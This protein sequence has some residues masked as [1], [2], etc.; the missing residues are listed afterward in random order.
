M[1]TNVK[2]FGLALAVAVAFVFIACNN[3]FFPAK[4]G[5]KPIVIIINVD[6]D[7]EDD[8]I[9]TK[10]HS[11][12]I[13]MIDNESGDSISA[14]PS[15][16]DVG[17]IVTLN[18]TVANTV[19]YNQLNFGGVSASIAQVPSAGSGTRTYTI[20]P[21]D[22]S[23]GGRIVIIATFNHTDLTLDPI[24]FATPSS[25]SKTYGDG[26]FTNA[27]TAR[28]GSG[29]ISYSSGDETVATVNGSGLVTIRKAGT[30][31][32]T[33]HKAEDAVYAAASNSYTLTVNPKPVTITGVT[34]ANKVYDGAT[35]ATISGTAAVSGL[36]GSDVVTV[37]N[38][39][40]AFADKNV[41]NGKTV[42]FSGFSLGGANAG[43]YSLS[44]PANTTANITAKPVTITGLTAAN[45]F[46]DGTTTATITG[47][48]T[49]NGLISGDVVTVNYGT[50]SFANATVGDNKTVTFS[51]FSLGGANAG[52]YSLSAQ[53]VSV[54]ANIA[55]SQ[56]A[57]PSN[58][59][60]NFASL[61]WTVVSNASG[62]VVDIDGTEFT[63]AT[64]SYPHSSLTTPKTYTI[65]VKAIGNG[66]TYTDSAW[67]ST[68]YYTVE[69]YTPGLEFTLID[70][71]TA[72]S[73]SRGTATDATVIIPSVYNG[74]PV[75]TIGDE[76]LNFGNY[77]TMTS[78]T[79]PSS[80]TS[81][82]ILAFS[83]CSGLTSVTIPNSV[84][85]IGGNAFTNCS[86]LT[87]VT[88]GNSVT[89]IGAFAFDGCSGLTSVTIPNSV[90]SIGPYAFSNC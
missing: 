80:V 47:T 11:I 72:Y 30:A 34:A 48:A 1:K 87:S 79:I 78:V 13:K 42:S 33:A 52:N 60:I 17:D 40:A 20:N 29:A 81:I 74:L 7:D 38:G 69:A 27:I 19:H 51:G 46:F 44:Q 56:L 37:N 75:T 85:S 39:T 67:S 43:N 3:P 61:T 8:I 88:I 55:I 25:I 10:P 36:V 2:L 16:G 32:I 83:G 62:Y 89:S 73:V 57:T 21:D 90:T 54:T 15:S 70:G 12:E 71:N 77:T 31:V 82:G 66:T 18:Y 58:L 68:V 50:A 4:K 76:I 35:T 14:V 5:T 86:G 63:V 24:A 9:T 84:T 59:Q 49:I 22:A 53:P 23:V 26:T 45:K 6:D 65:K 64:N 28:N 41:S